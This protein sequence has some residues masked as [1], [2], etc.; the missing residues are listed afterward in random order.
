MSDRDQ[1]E[2]GATSKSAAAPPERPRRGVQSSPPPRPKRSE[3]TPPPRSDVGRRMLTRALLMGGIVLF[4]LLLIAGLF[5]ALGITGPRTTTAADYTAREVEAIILLLADDPACRDTRLADSFNFAPDNISLE[6]LESV[7][8]QP[9]SKAG[10]HPIRIWTY[11][12]SDG[13]VG[14]PVAGVYD[15]PRYPIPFVRLDGPAQTFGINDTAPL[16]TAALKERILRIKSRFD[17]GDGAALETRRKEEAR[18]AEAK[19]A[20]WDRRDV[21]RF[22]RLGEE[23]MAAEQ[24]ER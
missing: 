13:T 7:V 18:K 10:R 11:K 20:E 17:E 23:R 14:I 1:T 19:Q 8:G 16:D 6:L 21:A 2:A 22:E 3:V 9:I 24:D 15:G 5:S 12:T 4:G